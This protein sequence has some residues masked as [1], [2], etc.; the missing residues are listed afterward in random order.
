MRAPESK[1]RLTI[2]LGLILMLSTLAT[3]I[4]NYTITRR[5]VRQE[6]LQSALPLTRDTIFSEIH[7]SLMRPLMVASSM[8]NDNFLKDWATGG[9]RGL[10]QITAYLEGLRAK[11]G[12]FTAFFISEHSKRYYYHGGVLKTLS[13]KDE[14]DVW[15]Y[16]FLESGEEHELDVDTNEAADNILTIFINFRVEDALGRLLGV[17]GVGLEMDV[18]SRLLSETQ[19]RFDRTV[20]FVDD[21]GLIQAHSDPDMIMTRYIEDMPGLDSVAADILAHTETPGEF[22]YDAHG[23]HYLLSVRYIPE[24]HWFLLVQ[25]NETEALATARANFLRTLGIGLAA[26]L[27]VITVTLFTVGS[28]QRRLMRM[29]TTDELTGVGNRREFGRRF[30][31]AAYRH[32]REGRVFCVILA[33]IDG[34]KPVNDTHGHMA[35]D[36]LLKRTAE[37]LEA[38]VRPTDVVARWGSM[39]LGSAPFPKSRMPSRA[40]SSTWGMPCPQPAS[41]RT[42]PP[43]ANIREIRLKWWRKNRFMRATVPKLP[44]IANPIQT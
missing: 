32:Q 18:V 28:Y 34:L 29:A 4:V 37:L 19:E 39:V 14:H 38:S 44:E 12:F 20:F 10:G 15:Y 31:L 24:F 33:D 22:E 41:S 9:E 11:Y 27:V 30:E 6:L 25:E 21:N 23:E 3:S 42:R 1:L 5:A 35:G 40:A 13:P 43:N 36:Q 7:S 17:T 8:A 26:S 16:S 2:V